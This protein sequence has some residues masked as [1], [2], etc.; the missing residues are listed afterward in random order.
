M[1][2]APT[3]R[4]ARCS[5]RRA[6]HSRTDEP[7]GAG[8]GARRAAG[9]AGRRWWW[10]RWWR[11]RGGG[12]GDAGR[13]PPRGG[14]HRASPWPC[15]TGVSSSGRG[16]G[17]LGGGRRHGHR[18][19][20]RPPLCGRIRVATHFSL[21]NTLTWL[22][23]VALATD[24]LVDVVRTRRPHRP[25]RAPTRGAS[26]RRVVVARAP[27]ENAA[28]EARTQLDDGARPRAR[29]G[30]LS[31]TPRPPPHRR[32][33]G[34]SPASTACAPSPPSSSSWCTPRSRRGSPCGR[35]RAS[36]RPRLEDRRVRRSS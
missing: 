5:H 4:G 36:T 8:R 25:A 21:A 3:R 23:V 28:G 26:A 1:G 34:T 9:R 13:R 17:P 20:G 30:R 19:A 32:G 29:F 12:R 35:G 15:P 18:R 24:A 10:R 2:A 27:E 14:R 22:A 33:P 31:S 11:G 7:T 16:R 6:M